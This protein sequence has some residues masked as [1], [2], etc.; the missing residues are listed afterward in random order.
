MLSRNDMTV[1]MRQVD[2][3]KALD[4]LTMFKEA[5]KEK[6]D[7][8]PCLSSSKRVMPFSPY[9]PTMEFASYNSIDTPEKKRWD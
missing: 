5:G 2:V 8:Q 6:I 9:F 1:L 4:L 7:V 3:E